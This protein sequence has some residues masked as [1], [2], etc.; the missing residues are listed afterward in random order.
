M[1]FFNQSHKPAAAEDFF[2]ISLVS[3]SS[4]LDSMR[5]I[6]HFLFTSFIDSALNFLS[7]SRNRAPF[8]ISDCAPFQLG[9]LII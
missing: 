6:A 9:S 4:F 1:M 7:C 2:L 8:F 3:K 5:S